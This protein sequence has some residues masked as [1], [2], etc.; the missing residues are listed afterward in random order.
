MDAKSIKNIQETFSLIVLPH[1]QNIKED[2]KDI[3]RKME[4]ITNGVV[5]NKVKIEGNKKDIQNI[6]SNFRNNILIAG[7]IFTA[8]TVLIKIFWR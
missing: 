8:I 5:N 1:I 4:K 3:N 2:I 6:K 7:L